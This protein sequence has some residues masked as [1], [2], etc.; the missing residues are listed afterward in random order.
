MRKVNDKRVIIAKVSHACLDHQ[1]NVATY[2]CI[3]NRNTVGKSFTKK[4]SERP[5]TPWIISLALPTLSHF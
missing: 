1:A 5:L 4:M 2:V 3:V